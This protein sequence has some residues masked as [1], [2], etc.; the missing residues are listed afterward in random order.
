MPMTASSKDSAQSGSVG[1]SHVASA[2]RAAGLASRSP[3]DQSQSQ[4]LGD[5]AL[6]ATPTRQMRSPRLPPGWVSSF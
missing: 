1:L 6:G 3:P 5:S 4:A 2:T